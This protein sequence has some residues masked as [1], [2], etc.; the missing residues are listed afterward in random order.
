M[1]SIRSDAINGGR[2]VGHCD[3]AFRSDGGPCLCC[4]CTPTGSA[5]RFDRAFAIGAGKLNSEHP[6]SRYSVDLSAGF[7]LVAG[8]I[9][10]DNSG[11]QG[12][13]G[14]RWRVTT[15]LEDVVFN[16]SIHQGV[17]GGFEI[18]PVDR[19]YDGRCGFGT[20]R[21]DLDPAPS[22]ELAGGGDDER[23]RPIDLGVFDSVMVEKSIDLASGDHGRVIFDQ[24]TGGSGLVELPLASV[25][26]R[27]EFRM[28]VDSVGHESDREG[29]ITRLRGKASETAGSNRYAP[30]ALVEAKVVVYCASYDIENFTQAQLD[31]Y[32]ANPSL[33]GGGAHAP[34]NAAGGS[35]TFH[36][37]RYDLV[38][39]C[40]GDSGSES[41]G[42]VL[43]ASVLEVYLVSSATRYEVYVGETGDNA[44]NGA[45]GY[46]ANDTAEGFDTVTPASFARTVVFDADEL[47]ASLE[48]TSSSMRR[49]FDADFDSVD[50]NNGN[51]DVVTVIEESRMES[52]R[53]EMRVVTV[54]DLGDGPEQTS[55]LVNQSGWVPGVDP[56]GNEDDELAVSVYRPCGA[57]CNEDAF[58]PL[59]P[60]SPG[61]ALPGSVEIDGKLYRWVGQTMIDLPND[62]YEPSPDASSLQC[63]SLA[64]AAACDPMTGSGVLAFT[65]DAGFVEG[66]TTV[67]GAPDDPR[68]YV[69]IIN[70]THSDLSSGQY[71]WTDQPC[72]NGDGVD[73]RI[74]NACRPDTVPQQITYDRNEMTPGSR[75]YI[76]GGDQYQL[77]LT[78]SQDAVSVGSFTDQLCPPLNRIARL[79]G[80]GS[81]FVVFDPATK[82]AGFEGFRVDE[83]LY[84]ATLEETLDDAVVG[85]WV[86]ERCEG[87]WFIAV[88]CGTLPGRVPTG[89]TYKYQ[90]ADLMAAGQGVAIAGHSYA[91]PHGGT[92]LIYY[93]VQPTTTTTTPPAGQDIVCEQREGACATATTT[94]IGDCFNDAGGPGG[95]TGNQ[96]QTGGS[97][98]GVNPN[99]AAFAEFYRRQLGCEGCSG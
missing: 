9:E 66:G 72:P 38:A 67:I 42:M 74:A 82:P 28:I 59:M 27:V 39:G 69:H 94:R 95:I 63:F 2:L 96:L 93:A 20:S 6:V 29:M 8:T 11:D 24:R 65:K 23:T 45:P 88:P 56:N 58:V 15:L 77:T 97:R 79:C 83:L 54:D 99:D 87:D 40:P 78:A 44:F 55:M 53:L 80:D 75:G 22:W 10:V 61:D 33:T 30:C 64:L 84:I 37:H 48:M 36:D 51:F 12:G 46:P 16:A 47:L 13:D 1:S 62:A 90:L 49:L 57:T 86:D 32:N 31:F 18:P 17:L 26:Y 91:G 52:M 19:S 35:I 68:R 50:P 14:E 34:V 5:Y 25:T 76:V 92:C 71:A 60:W 98:V 3:G 7:S 73:R 21:R 43:F 85:Q 81:V 89:L 4:G 70:S 41:L